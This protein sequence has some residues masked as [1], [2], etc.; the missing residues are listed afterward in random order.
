MKTKPGT[1]VDVPAYLIPGI[2]RHVQAREAKLS[3][4]KLPHTFGEIVS[5]LPGKRPR[6]GAEKHGAPGAAHHVRRYI[7]AVVAI[8]YLTSHGDNEKPVVAMGAQV[9]AAY[10]YAPRDIDDA[11]VLC[12]LYV[13]PHQ[14]RRKGSKTGVPRFNE[15]PAL[16]FTQKSFDVAREAQDRNVR[17]PPFTS[18]HDRLMVDCHIHMRNGDRYVT[19]SE[20]RP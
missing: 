3:K 1:G 19:A 16:H 17:F 12:V 6:Q 8:P 13:P 15:G 11:G 7:T 14:Q 9:Y 18:F 20:R 10:R 2:S 4:G 5:K